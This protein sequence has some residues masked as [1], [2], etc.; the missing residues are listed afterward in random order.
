M[1]A[2][3]ADHFIRLSKSTL[4][5][6]LFNVCR[7]GLGCSTLTWAPLSGLEGELEL[8]WSVVMWLSHKTGLSDSLF[9]VFLRTHGRLKSE[10]IDATD[11]GTEVTTVDFFTS[12]SDF[13]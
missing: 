7:F 2:N 9:L 8:L 13:Q 6:T 3:E 1:C 12:G 11:L 4:D 5:F 10:G